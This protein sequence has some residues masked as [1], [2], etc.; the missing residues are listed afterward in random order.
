MRE[1]TNASTQHVFRRHGEESV[2]TSSSDIEVAPARRVPTI[3][4]TVQL[5]EIMARDVVC[6][7]D[8]LDVDALVEL[9][10]SHRIGCVP[11]VDRDGAPIGMV[12]NR[13]LVDDLLRCRG[14]DAPAIL[15]VRRLMM[16][17]VFTLEE[18]ATVA[19]A[20]AMMA[21]EDIHHV[22]VVAETGCLVGVV[23]SMDIVRWLAA[24][25]GLLR[26]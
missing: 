20:A 13:D 2:R 21:V 8:D 9:M 11:I 5:H 26:I 22:A 1:I 18:H 14:D 4:D 25:D 6:A 24:N 7:R 16:P 15:E 3:A 12:T 19:H 23:S 17:L 10:A